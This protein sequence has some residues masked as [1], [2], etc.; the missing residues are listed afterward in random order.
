MHEHR[1]FELDAVPVGYFTGCQWR[2]KVMCDQR[3]QSRDKAC[4]DVMHCPGAQHSTSAEIIILRFFYFFHIGSGTAR[5]GMAR[6]IAAPSPREAARH[7][8][9]GDGIPRRCH[10][11]LA[12]RRKAPRRRR[13]SRCAEWHRDAPCRAM[14]CRAV[15]CRIRCQSV[16]L[17]WTGIGSFGW[18]CFGSEVFGS[19]STSTFHFLES[20][21]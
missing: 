18:T 12:W 15:P 4:S 13:S 7:G 19:Q 2:A 1:D 3:V 14:P 17:H 8:T 5:Y 6:C 9:I 20:F 11:P 10:P 16:I 21:V